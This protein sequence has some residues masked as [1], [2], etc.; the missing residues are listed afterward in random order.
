MAPHCRVSRHGLFN[1][2]VYTLKSMR[3]SSLLGFPD[4]DGSRS[5]QGMESSF[6][7]PHSEPLLEDVTD[8]SSQGLAGC[9]LHESQWGYLKGLGLGENC[10][11][12]TN[13]QLNT[14][15]ALVLQMFWGF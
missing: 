11:S 12:D 5:G 6:L 10:R 4:D 13:H 14:C 3:D 15:M 9:R 7:S 1:T 8:I 2:D